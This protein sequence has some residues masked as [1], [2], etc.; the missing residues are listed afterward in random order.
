M[1]V[2]VPH[3]FR[4]ESDRPA[5][6]LISVAPAGFERMFFEVGVELPAGAR[7]APPPTHDEIERL[8]AVAP[9]YGVTILPP[10][11]S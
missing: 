1:P 11:G 4:S 2:G 7:S 10:P 6:M 9:R 3:P 8:L 5:R